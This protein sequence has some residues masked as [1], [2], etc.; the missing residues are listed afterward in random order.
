[1]ARL[2]ELSPAHRKWVE[3]HAWRRIAPLPQ[4]VRPVAPDRGR[5][6][7]IS[8]AGFVLPGM[9]PFRKRLGGDDSFRRL[10]VELDTA[11][12]I[13]SHRS[14]AFDH[15]ALDRDPQLGLPLDVLRDLVTQGELGALHETAYSFMGSITNPRRLIRESAPEVA[16]ELVRA[17]VDLALLV[18]V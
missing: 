17:Q 7:L 15:E 16:R 9:P 8:S 5:L 12:L 4:V 10:P 1:M 11:Q 6:A 18:P 14:S 3:K 2:E 13:N